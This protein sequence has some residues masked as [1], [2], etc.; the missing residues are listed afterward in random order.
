MRS[1]VRIAVAQL[2][3]AYMDLE[4]SLAI[5]EKAILE[6]GSNG[7]QLIAFPETFLPGFPVWVFAH[8]GWKD[9]RYLK[10]RAHLLEN[11]VE[12]P[13]QATARLC[14]AARTANITVAI[15]IN[16]RDTSFSR[17][18]IYN[19]L[20]YISNEGQ[21]LGVHRKLKPTHGERIIWGEGDGSGLR[22]FDT[23]AGRLGGLICWEH[24]MPLSRFAMHALGE[25]VHVAAYPHFP[26]HNAL[27]AQHYA[28]EGRCFVIAAGAILRKSDITTDFG[29]PLDSL[30]N[31]ART[32]TNDKEDDF[33]LMGGSGII[34]P[35]GK[36]IA[37]PTFYE[38]EIMYADID[39]DDVSKGKLSLDVAGHYNR[40]DIF[41]LTVD[42]RV[43][44]QVVWESEQV[45]NH[46][47]YPKEG[48]CLKKGSQDT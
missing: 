6:A 3:P 24:W 26:E 32:A 38:E 30:K 40:P 37:G 28:F 13:S 36:W 41:Q 5:A 45:P 29:L 44:S 18:T 22:A 46:D 7:A 47:S 43:K 21:I 12:I 19:S 35:E 1:T 16:E 25:E 20:L 33:I 8:T 4:G 23:A 17:Q 11:S 48:H 15:G 34:N 27:A 42:N 14:D 9:E 2:Q 39:L 31:P 10:A